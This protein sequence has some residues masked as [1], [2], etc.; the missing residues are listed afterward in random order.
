MLKII[1]APLGGFRG[2]EKGREKEKGE[3]NKNR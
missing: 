2:R 1:I 3:K